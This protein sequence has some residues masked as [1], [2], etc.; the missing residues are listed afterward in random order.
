MG[1]KQVGLKDPGTLF[2][3][4]SPLDGSAELPAETLE[5]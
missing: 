2:G 4:V 5:L 3:L 1:G